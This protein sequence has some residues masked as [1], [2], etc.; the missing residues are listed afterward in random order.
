MEW[1]IVATVKAPIIRIQ[2]FI[3]Y[4]LQLGASKIHIFFDDPDDPAFSV[5]RGIPGVRATRCDS[6]HW[7]RYNG[8]PEQHQNRQARNAMRAYFS[9]SVSWLCHIDIDE[10]LFPKQSIS[11]I[12]SSLPAEQSMLRMEPFEAIHNSV[13]SEDIFT[14]CAFRGPLSGRYE[15]LLPIVFGK[16]SNIL[17]EGMLSHGSGKAF[18][19]TGIRGFVPRIHG[20]SLNGKRISGMLFESRIKLLHFHAEDR[21]AW[22]AALPY[23]LS[24]GAYR[25]R[26]PLVQL[27]GK[28]SPS[29]VQEFY[30]QTQ[31]LNSDKLAILR[32]EGRL[33][34]ADLHLKRAVL[35]KFQEGFIS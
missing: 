26:L 7:E 34:E 10:F 4:H 23:R 13:I 31:M 28:G 18:F 30:Q 15:G 3:A 24:K 27:L 33:V 2:A 21:E 14:A 11:E 19:R 32:G 25:K 12:V 5:V 29:E 16:Y 1:G 20:A 6:K 17:P 8:R 35:H 22:L 9:T